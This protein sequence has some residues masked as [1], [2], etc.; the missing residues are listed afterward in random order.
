MCLCVFL[1]LYFFFFSSTSVC[2][3]QY[4]L[5][6]SFTGYHS[7]VVFLLFFFRFSFYAFVLEEVRVVQESKV[8]AFTAAAGSVRQ[9][10][11]AT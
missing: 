1:T 5:T 3:S 7:E 10:G 11:D 9:S 6:F 4:K 8:R 2:L